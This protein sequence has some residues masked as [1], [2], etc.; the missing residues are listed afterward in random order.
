M[1]YL[2]S[3]VQYRTLDEKN[4]MKSANIVQVNSYIDPEL[5]E[6][7]FNRSRKNFVSKSKEIYLLLQRARK[8]IERKK[9]ATS[10]VHT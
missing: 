10:K 2:G 7:I 9:N 4:C 5:D 1:I 6:W 8:E 3:T